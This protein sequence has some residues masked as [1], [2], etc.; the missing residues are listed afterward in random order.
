MSE[1][2]HGV[3]LAQ[4]GNQAR[5]RG[6]LRFG[7]WVSVEVAHE[8]DSDTVGVVSPTMR[9]H[10]FKGARG[11]QGSV[12]VYDVVIG[13]V[14]VAPTLDAG[15]ELFKARVYG[16]VVHDD[17]RNLPHGYLSVIDLTAMSNRSWAQ[18]RQGSFSSASITARS[19]RRS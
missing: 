11:V 8:G 6:D 2:G 13:D 17:L 16:C 19:Q 18:L 9:P 12:G 4:A 3:L 10:A 5:E 7:G 15:A 1:H 14:G